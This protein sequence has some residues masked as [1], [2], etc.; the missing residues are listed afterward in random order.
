MFYD[1]VLRIYTN[2][3]NVR[4]QVTGYAGNH[5]KRYKTREEVEAT[6]SQ[7]LAEQSDYY[8][9]P[10]IVVHDV[11]KIKE[12]GAPK[13]VGYGEESR[14]KDFIIVGLVFSIMYFI[15]S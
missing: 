5:H 9:P 1:K 8:K 10:K 15:L 4:L 2:L 3:D 13:I 7:F 6:Y 12:H 11:L 14:L